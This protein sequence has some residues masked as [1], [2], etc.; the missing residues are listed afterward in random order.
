MGVVDLAVDG[1]GHPVA[2][3]R[4]FLHGSV[5]EMARA[6][7]RI[8]R[9]AEALLSLDHPNIVRLLDVI[10]DGDEIVLVMPYLSG[11]TL[12]DQVRTHGPL[13]PD[14]VRILAAT[15]LSAL[16]SAHRHGVIHRDIKP[17]NV[18]F[19]ADGE[20][21]LADFGVASLRDATSGLTASGMMV[22]TPEFMAPEQARGE[23]ATAASDVF[24]LGATLAFAATGMPPYGRGDPRVL[25]QR[26]A[27]G[28]V[29]PLPSHLPSDLRRFLHPM[30][31]KNPR[32]RPTAAAARGGSDGTHVLPAPRRR[33]WKG[34]LIGAAVGAIGTIAMLLILAGT[35]PSTD[36]AQPVSSPTT[37][38]QPTTTTEPCQDQPF[39]PC[40]GPI[41]PFTDGVR[42]TDDHADYDGKADNGCEASPDTVDGQSLTAPVSAN[43]VPGTDIDR[44]PFH[45]GDNLDL[46]CD[47]TLKVTLTS[48]K[49]ATMHLDVMRDRTILGSATSDNGKP[50]T[51]TLRE[52]SC[53]GDDSA[54]LVARVSWSG[55]ARTDAP[56][57][58][59]RSGSF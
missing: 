1:T 59:E 46:L 2:I 7:Q 15:L 3:K 54:D 55:T 19:D 36:L 52:P 21:Y 17:A 57:R 8:R 25:V 39:H 27:S 29:H 5:H 11:G 48:P 38:A 18:L 50:A 33:R 22:G 9:E 12:A 37:T 42:C 43:L 14:H 30:L 26:A 51:V 20:P 40:G 13:Q 58:L 44:Y 23:R 16:A 6:R 32:K 28:K 56:Y 35:Q 45:V 53:L 41:A 47:G 4:L 34:A 49:G 31:A 24:S 10:D